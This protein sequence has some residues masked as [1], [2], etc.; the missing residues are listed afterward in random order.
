MT[1]PSARRT[2]YGG[3]LKPESWYSPTSSMPSA[4]R[5]GGSGAAVCAGCAGAPFAPSGVAPSA[6]P[7]GALSRAITFVSAVAGSAPL[8][9]VSVAMDGGRGATGGAAR[10]RPSPWRA[11]T[12]AP[13]A[14]ALQVVL[15]DVRGL[16]R[17]R[18]GDRV[19]REH[20]RR[21]RRVDRRGQ[22]GVDQ[23]HRGALGQLLARELVELLAGQRPVLLGAV[24][25]HRSF[26][27]ERVVCGQL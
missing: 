17:V 19:V 9:G 10:G 22:V 20:V 3:S 8:G 11:V 14:R 2:M 4:R 7:A 27:G 1:W 25:S 12:L 21:H 24:V 26:S 23:R 18:V 5:G 15:R 16:R 13:G 6:P